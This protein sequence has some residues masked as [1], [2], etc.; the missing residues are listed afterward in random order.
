M[1]RTPTWCRPESRRPRGAHPVA[2][3]FR[4]ETLPVY[5]IDFDTDSYR[6]YLRGEPPDAAK[7][8]P[9]YEFMAEQ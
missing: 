6:S 7:N 9:W 5:P 2:G 4:L 8:V 1:I 3:A